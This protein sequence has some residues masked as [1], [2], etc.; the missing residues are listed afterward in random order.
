MVAWRGG[1]IVAWWGVGGGKGWDGKGRGRE[2]V[3]ASPEGGRE[4]AICEFR[5]GRRPAGK[6]QT[7]PTNSKHQNI[8][9]QTHQ[10][11]RMS[12]FQDF[13]ISGYQNIRVSESPDTRT[14]GHRAS[15]HRGI[16]AL[17]HQNIRTSEHDQIRAKWVSR[18]RRWAIRG[19]GCRWFRRMRMMLGSHG[20]AVRARAPVRGPG[21]GSVGVPACHMRHV[22]RGVGWEDDWRPGSGKTQAACGS[23]GTDG[24]W[25][26]GVRSPE[27]GVRSRESGVQCPVS[28]VRCPGSGVRCPVSGIGCGDLEGRAGTE[29]E[30]WDIGS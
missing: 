25:K 29:S 28:G 6:P 14:R 2:G 18:S 4:G 3:G 8:K 7:S 10:N 16:K 23:E 24:K 12:G 20:P 30:K 5:I 1:G 26:P 27:S 19:S 15:E 9:H 17:E 11:I 22:P 21:P 13:R